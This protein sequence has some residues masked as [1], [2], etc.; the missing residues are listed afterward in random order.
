[1]EDGDITKENQ[2]FQDFF[3]KRK[4]LNVNDIEVLK[5]IKIGLKQPH[6]IKLNENLTH[7][8]FDRSFENAYGIV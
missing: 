8:D 5:N 3:D 7:K 4:K 1:M 2:C 6:K